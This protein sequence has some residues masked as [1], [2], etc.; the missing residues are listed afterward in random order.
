M[1][2]C[3][4]TNTTCLIKFPALKAELLDFVTV[5]VHPECNS[6]CQANAHWSLSIHYDLSTLAFLRGM[7]WGEWVAALTGCITYLSTLII[8][9]SCGQA[10][11]SPLL[12]SAPLTSTPAWIFMRK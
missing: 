12:L 6:I 10:F 4:Y 3:A 1:C 2:T 9:V 8:K 5:L 11:L 7:P